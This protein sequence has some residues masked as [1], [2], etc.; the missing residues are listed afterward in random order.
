MRDNDQAAIK[1]PYLETQTGVAG[2]KK[3]A[4]AGGLRAHLNH[5]P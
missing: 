2:S 4:F 1:Y 3:A 5:Y